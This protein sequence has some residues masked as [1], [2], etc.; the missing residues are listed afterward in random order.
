MPIGI[1]LEPAGQADVCIAI[2]NTRTAHAN[3]II[4]PRAKR[5]DWK[6]VFIELFPALAT[7]SGT[8]L[9]QQEGGIVGRKVDVGPLAPLE[10][11]EI[12]AV[13]SGVAILHFTATWCGACA[14][15]APETDALCANMDRIGVRVIHIWINDRRL[16]AEHVRSMK[17]RGEHAWEPLAG[18]VAKQFGVTHL[19]CY[20]VLRGENVEEV[21]PLPSIAQRVAL[22]LV[23][24]PLPHMRRCQNLDD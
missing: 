13:G 18:P 19:P 14:W 15:L 7:E 5:L 20:I 16:A 24:S 3:V 1:W 4:R 11:D 23:G 22:H 2:V 8:L 10:G 21:T 17:L 9:P 12:D 6:F